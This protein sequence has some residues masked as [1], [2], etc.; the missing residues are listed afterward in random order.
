MTQ[1]AFFPSEWMKIFR[2]IPEF[3]KSASKYLISQIII[4]SL[5]YFQFDHLNKVCEG[6]ILQVLRF[7]FLK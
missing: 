7:E 2:I 5:I 1:S 6:V 3:S 4:V